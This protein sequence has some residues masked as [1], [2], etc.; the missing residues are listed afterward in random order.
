MWIKG[1][2]PLHCETQDYI[3]MAEFLVWVGM[4]GFPHQLSQGCPALS[5]MWTKGMLSPHGDMQ[6][7]IM[8]EVLVWVA[9]Q[10]LPH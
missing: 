3:I 1:K 4:L 2:L 6:D 8:S 10:G 7:Y 9:W 5:A